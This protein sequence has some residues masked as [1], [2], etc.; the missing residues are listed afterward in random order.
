MTQPDI[1]LEFNSNFDL[2]LFFAFVFLTHKDSFSLL[3]SCNSDYWLIWLVGWS[4][5]WLAGWLVRWLAGWLVRRLAG[6]MVGWLAGNL[7]C[8]DWL[9]DILEDWSVTKYWMCIGTGNVRHK[10]VTNLTL[11][12]FVLLPFTNTVLPSMEWS[13]DRIVAKSLKWNAKP[14]TIL[15]LKPP[16]IIPKVRLKSS[17]SF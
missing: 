1:S 4:A 12:K 3:K 9:T 7:L 10:T 17:L 6:W 15:R 13:E 2:V 11:A 14:K 5:G 8:T 16:V